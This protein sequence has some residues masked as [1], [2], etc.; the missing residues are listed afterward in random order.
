ML[1]EIACLLKTT[2]RVINELTFRISLSPSSD[3]SIL[4]MLA[5]K[6]FAPGDLNA[7]SLLLPKN[8]LFL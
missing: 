6:K 2:F 1:Y 7:N 3:D 8:G 5:S 4:V